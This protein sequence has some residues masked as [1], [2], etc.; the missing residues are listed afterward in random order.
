MALFDSLLNEVNE[1]FNLGDKGEA[2]L[3]GLLSLITKNAGGGLNGFLDMFHRA[4]LGETADSWAS[5][6]ANGALSN[7]Q[8]E[9]ALGT[10]T[11]SEL[12]NQAGLP[13]A[14]A[15]AA[16][17]YLI[18]TVVD[19]LTPDGVVP[20]ENSLR[21]MLGNY[22]SGG[23][24]SNAIGTE[25]A[26]MGGMPDRTDAATGMTTVNAATSDD[27]SILRWVLPLVLLGLLSF[28]GYQFCGKPNQNVAITNV[29]ARTNINTGSTVTNNNTTV[30][31]TN[32]SN[33]ATHSEANTH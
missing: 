32:N 28:V 24:A 8:T 1:R 4:G 12:A 7:Q 14:T 13:T 27:N 16:L 5:R 23:T 2:L 11:L 15:A 26:A 6:G 22:S 33:A 3:S 21:S 17:S 29:N 18:P 9:D 30:T 10:D 20:N 25:R 31:T 19:K